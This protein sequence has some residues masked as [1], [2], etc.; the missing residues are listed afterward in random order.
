MRNL[1][2]VY[3]SDCRIAARSFSN[4]F[5]PVNKEYQTSHP[6]WLVSITQ[7]SHSLVETSRSINCTQGVV[8]RGSLR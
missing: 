2:S 8:A 1:G 6:L 7:S 3:T 5:A 4:K